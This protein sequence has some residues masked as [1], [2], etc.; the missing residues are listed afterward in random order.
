MKRRIVFVLCLALL[1]SGCVTQAPVETTAPPTVAPTTLPA[2]TTAPTTMPTEPTETEP[3]APET[4]VATALADHT[5]LVLAWVNREDTVQIVGEFDETHYIVQL[6]S[7]YGLIEKRLVRTEGEAAYETWSG[8]AKSGAMFCDNYHLISLGAQKLSKNAKL[9]VLDQMGDTCLVQVDE[10]IGYLPLSK[11]SKTYI[12]SSGSSSSDG[13]D[14]SLSNQPGLIPLS[15][16]VPQ[17]GDVTGSA[18][19]L[20][21][22]AEIMLGWFDRNDTIPV[23]A[24]EG[25]AEVKDGWH[26]VY[27]DGV[28]GYVRQNLVFM[29][30]A[31]V[32]TAWEGYAKSKTGAYTNYYLTGE[33]AE[34]LSSN[35]KVT[36]LWD[37]D[38]CY[39][40][41]IG[42]NIRFLDKELV[43]EKK[44]SS[45]SSGGAEW[46]DP[47]M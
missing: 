13:G 14:I 12:K 15:V 19:V 7:G 8:Y 38:F 30:G 18:T 35:T 41:Q 28:Y 31:E 27:L 11:I 24:E 23:I 21:D 36:V 1:L 33:A 9:T 45:G 37:L 17:E 29:E 4:A 10:A 25:F 43:S 2:E 3:P 20:C 34:S 22:G 39:M 5:A 42:E 16:F 44:W 32:Y 46:S 40:V 26:A 6:D 47:V